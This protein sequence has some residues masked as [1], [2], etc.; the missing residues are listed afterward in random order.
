MARISRT[1]AQL[2]KSRSE[3]RS[4]AVA[5]MR[6]HFFAAGERCFKFDVGKKWHLRRG[7]KSAGFVQQSGRFKFDW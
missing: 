2:Y 7:E 6:G 4:G 1:V 3:V 5:F